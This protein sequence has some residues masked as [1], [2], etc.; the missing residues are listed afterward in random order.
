MM[1]EHVIVWIILLHHMIVL[2]CRTRHTALVEDLRALQEIQDGEKI[3]GEAFLPTR[4]TIF[5]NTVHKYN[6]TLII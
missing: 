4:Y 5:A 1:F 6:Y 2:L 3:V